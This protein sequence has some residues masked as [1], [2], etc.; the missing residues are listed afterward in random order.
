MTHPIQ[1]TQESMSSATQIGTYAEFTPK[2]KATTLAI[3]HVPSATLHGKLALSSIAI[4]MGRGVLM[5]QVMTLMSL[6]KTYYVVE[7]VFG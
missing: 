2:Q 3:L 4:A 6:P 7:S 1:S 5:L